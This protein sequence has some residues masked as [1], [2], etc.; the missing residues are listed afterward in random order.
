MEFSHIPN[1]AGHALSSGARPMP[2]GAQAHEDEKALSSGE[3]ATLGRIGSLLD[4]VIA[5]EA[6]EPS[7]GNG[8]PSVDPRLS[9]AR[10]LTQ[11]LINSS[12]Y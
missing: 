3:A 8:E 7:E 6:G 11:A 5:E 1:L 12:S 2:P 10:S 9:E 4:G